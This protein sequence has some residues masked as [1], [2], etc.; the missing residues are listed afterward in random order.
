M[1]CELFPK[2]SIF[3]VKITS[4]YPLEQLKLKNIY[5]GIN[6]MFWQGHRTMELSYISREIVN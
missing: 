5:M 4:F 6:T 2:E 1:V 3:D